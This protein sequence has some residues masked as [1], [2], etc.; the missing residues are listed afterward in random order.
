M[1]SVV[2]SIRI[3]NTCASALYKAECEEEIVSFSATCVY[4]NEK[5]KIERRTNDHAHRPSAH[6][7]ILLPQ[8]VTSGA[9]W[10]GKEVNR[11]ENNYMKR[12]NA[13]PLTPPYCLPRVP[14]PLAMHV[15]MRSWLPFLTASNNCLVA[16]AC[17]KMTRQSTPNKDKYSST[18]MNKGV[19]TAGTMTYLNIIRKKKMH[20]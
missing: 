13:A 7:K 5:T 8:P 6:V 1:L 12:T 20:S 4:C 2:Q 19:L 18:N 14:A 15:L 11:I 17:L 3:C 9:L 10:P 16:S